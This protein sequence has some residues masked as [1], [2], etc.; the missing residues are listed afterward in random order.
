MLIW[1]VWNKNNTYKWIQRWYKGQKSELLES[2][3]KLHVGKLTELG[4]FD[5]KNNKVERG[6]SECWF[7]KQFSL[8]DVVHREDKDRMS[9]TWKTR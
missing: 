5:L 8:S 7:F 3:K 6:T 2:G 1:M 4:T 9:T